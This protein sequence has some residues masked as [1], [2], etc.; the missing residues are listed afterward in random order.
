MATVEPEL[1]KG[2]M[3]KQARGGLVRNWQNR[4]FV[5]D[6]GK[7]SYYQ[8]ELSRY[9]YGDNLKVCNQMQHIFSMLFLF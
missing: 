2:W 1:K 7:I 5:L 9:P 3:R 8:Q 4:F 6:Q